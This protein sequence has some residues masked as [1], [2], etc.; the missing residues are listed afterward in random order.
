M[1]YRLI[2]TQ[3]G[4]LLKWGTSVNQI[5]K[6][7]CSIFSFQQE[8]FQND[9]ITSVRAQIIYNWIL[10]LAQQEMK[11][12]ERDKLLVRFCMEITPEELKENVAEILITNG[13]PYNL[14]YKNSL[15]EF[16]KRDFHPE[17]IKHSKRLFLQANYFHAVFEASKAYNSA[18]KE[19]AQSNKDGEPLM[20]SVWAC[21]NGVLKITPCQSET[22]KNVQDGIKFLSAGLMR[23]IRNP[24]AHEPAA[25]W[26]IERKDCLDI[27]S[28]ISFLYRQLDKAVYFN[29]NNT[30]NENPSPIQ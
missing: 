28:F 10:S 3:V 20:L 5:N 2:A 24:T 6:T 11:G 26:P 19:K 29:M 21:T 17:I 1:N 15:E 30:K 25:D 4:D 22:D 7:A 8:N 12:E 27:L 23:A 13:L 14:V 18:V 9:S 16:S